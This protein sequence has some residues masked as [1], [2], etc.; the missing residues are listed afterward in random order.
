MKRHLKVH[1]LLKKEALDTYK[2][3]KH[4]TVI[5]FDVLMATSTI[6]ACFTFGAKE[7]YPVLHEQEATEMKNYL[8]DKNVL[9]AGER[10]GDMIEGFL[11]PL[12][13]QLQ[14]Q[15]K[16]KTLILSTTNGTVAIR[17]ASK[18]NQVY[19]GSLLNVKALSNKL[20]HLNDD[21][22]I[23]IVCAG[24]NNTFC[25]EDFYGAGALI[26]QLEEDSPEGECDLTD[27]ALAAKLFFKAHEARPEK[28]LHRS[29]VGKTMV[30]QGFGEELAFVSQVSKT[31]IVPFLQG[32][33]IV[34]K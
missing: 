25:L 17:K 3:K 14:Q 7:I 6:V 4:H 30:A 34:Y 10:D 28:I 1:V 21:H 31:A 11:A 5:I 16:G 12:P 22:T 33:K 2:I 23:L 32:N 18:A 20:L 29:Q 24:S 26:Q 8:L 27:S 19:I 15:I 9:I 13:L